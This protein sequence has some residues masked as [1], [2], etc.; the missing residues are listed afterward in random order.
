M[1]LSN[2]YEVISKYM[3]GNRLALNSDKTHFMIISSQ[4]QHRKNNYS[5]VILDT[6]SEIIK[7]SENE[8][9]LG[10]HVSNDLSWN[11]HCTHS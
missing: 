7:P 5:G 1:L 8:C 11:V 6:G 3:L 2:R 4:S 9:I 10:L